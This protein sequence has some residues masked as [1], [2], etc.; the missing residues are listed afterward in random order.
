MPAVYL[1]HLSKHLRFEECLQYV[2][3]PELRMQQRDAYIRRLSPEKHES[4]LAVLQT[5]CAG[6]T[7]AVMIFDWLRKRDVKKIVRVIVMDGKEVP[8]TDEAIVESLKDFEVEV[9]DWRKFDTCSETIR[10]AAKDVR[11]LHLYSS[12]INAVLR[13]WSS[14]QGLVLLE[15]V[16]PFFN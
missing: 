12:G 6:L 5:Q 3:L 11:I 1:E 15:K 16:R 13:G 7:D 2:A 4:T 10:L 14:E 8:H 9:W